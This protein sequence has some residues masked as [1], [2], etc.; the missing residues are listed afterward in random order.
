[1]QEKIGYRQIEKTIKAQ[2]MVVPK[3]TKNAQTTDAAFSKSPVWM[4]MINDLYE[5]YEKKA[6]QGDAALLMQK[7]RGMG[8]QFTIKAATIRTPVV[9]YLVRAGDATQQDVETRKRFIDFE[10]AVTTAGPKGVLAKTTEEGRD[11]DADLKDPLARVMKHISV[12]RRAGT[13]GTPIE[14]ADD[15]SDEE[16]GGGEAGEGEEDLSTVAQG[17]TAKMWPCGIINI[18]DLRVMKGDVFKEHPTGRFH[19]V[20]WDPPWGYGKFAGDNKQLTD[21]QVCASCSECLIS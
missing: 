3:P 1:M 12:Q 7:L 5:L 15:E 8:E 17:G 18:A 2:C 4:G 19:A 10:T 14:S 9:R 11:D 16:M 6:V 21:Q 13:K 20:F